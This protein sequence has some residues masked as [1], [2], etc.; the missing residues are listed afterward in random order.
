MFEDA[1]FNLMA[2]TAASNSAA[3]LLGLLAVSSL[4]SCWEHPYMTI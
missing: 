1:N 2:P 3:P 4:A